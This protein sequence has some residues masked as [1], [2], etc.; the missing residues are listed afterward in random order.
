MAQ[1][2][3]MLRMWVIDQLGPDDTDSEPDDVVVDDRDVPAGGLD[4]EV[5]E[6]GRSDV[7]RQAAVDQLG[8]EVRRSRG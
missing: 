7:D 6:Q 5:A 3:F 2:D 4:V 8:S 1:Q